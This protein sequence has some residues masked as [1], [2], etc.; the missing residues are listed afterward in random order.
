MVQVESDKDVLDHE[1]V[2]F[3]QYLVGQE[4]THYVKEKYR[5]AHR[6]M[7][8]S[9]SDTWNRFDR[10][11]VRIAGIRPWATKLID[12]YTRALQPY[13]LVRKKLILLLAIL[14]S[15][16]PTH[17]YLDR[18]DSANVVRILIAA[19]RRC[20]TFVFLLMVVAL[21]LV[22]L[23]LMVRG[24]VKIAKIWVPRHG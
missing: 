22:P 17:E 1:C 18:V 16:A 10:I 19:F 21:L 2:V 13:S 8:L 23:S 20:F 3:C 9:H 7:T 5:E 14:E 4:P 6:G 12:V 24:S 15:C 11:L